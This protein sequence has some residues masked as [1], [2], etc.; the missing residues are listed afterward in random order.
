VGFFSPFFP[1]HSSAVS[2]R[3]KDV[4]RSPLLPSFFFFFLS[5]AAYPL[6]PFPSIASRQVGLVLTAF[7]SWERFFPF[8]RGL[9]FFIPSRNRLIISFFEKVVYFFLSVMRIGLSFFSRRGSSRGYCWHG[10]PS[11]PPIPPL[12]GST[13]DSLLVFFFLLLV[14]CRQHL[15]RRLFGHSCCSSSRRRSLRFFPLSP[16][17]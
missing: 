11:W 5:R 9:S 4:R 8:S 10:F 13:S 14:P 1:R 2:S 16:S 12:M 15:S 17:D 3:R 7:R 6:V